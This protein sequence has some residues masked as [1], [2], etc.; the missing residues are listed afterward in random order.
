M[1]LEMGEYQV[2]LSH[3]KMNKAGVDIQGRWMRCSNTAMTYI[4]GSEL[5]VHT[6]QGQGVGA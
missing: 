4:I 6:A 1:K 3:S 2:D 5:W